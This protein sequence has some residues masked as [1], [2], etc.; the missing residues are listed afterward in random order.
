MASV[1]LAAAALAVVLLCT[2]ATASRSYRPEPEHED[3]KT[4]AKYFKN[5]L[6]FGLG[7]KCCREANVVADKQC[8]CEVEREAEIECRHTG[9]TSS[10][11]CGGIAGKIKIAEMH[12]SCLQPKKLK[13]KRA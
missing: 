6:S 12:L 7:E 13:C 1:K 10:A 5:C 8:L 4:Q 3:C 2:A 11:R 9:H